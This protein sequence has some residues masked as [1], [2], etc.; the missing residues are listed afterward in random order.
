MNPFPLFHHCKTLGELC[1]GDFGMRALVELERLGFSL[2]LSP[3]IK[4]ASVNTYNY[5]DASLDS[6]LL[7]VSHV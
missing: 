3:S 6:L 1:F 2:V 4:K 5:M 7:C